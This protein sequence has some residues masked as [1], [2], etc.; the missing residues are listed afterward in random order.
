MFNVLFKET[1]QISCSTASIYPNTRAQIWVKR[2]W[3]LNSYFSKSS[4]GQKSSRFFQ[5][6]V[7]VE[8]G[9]SFTKGAIKK[10]GR[11]WKLEMWSL[12]NLAFD[13]L[14]TTR[15]PEAA[16]WTPSTPTSLTNER[17]K[18]H[19]LK[20]SKSATTDRASRKTYNNPLPCDTCF[21]SK[22]PG[23]TLCGYIQVPLYHDLMILLS[24]MD[25]IFRPFRF[26]NTFSDLG[27]GSTNSTQS[28]WFRPWLC[29]VLASGM[30]HG[31]QWR[32]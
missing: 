14:S 7:W 6:V 10:A 12:P 15:D 32:L 9:S 24:I 27:S 28:L 3:L 11:W 19:P 13:C 30:R 17:P 1:D 16:P 4:S 18:V 25:V 8:G 23:F 5:G 26:D 21:L 31:F 2:T 29:Q 20:G 22:E